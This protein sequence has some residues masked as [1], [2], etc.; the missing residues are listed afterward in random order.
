MYLKSV[1]EEVE[2]LNL[3]NAERDE[4]LGQLR[5]R[6]DEFSQR[7]RILQD[8]IVSAQRMSDEMQQKA[9]SEADLLLREARMNAERRL[10]ESQDQLSRIENEISRL[11]L[12][13]DSF[14]KRLRGL[15]EQHLELLDLRSSE[16][17]EQEGAN[18]MHVLPQASVYEAG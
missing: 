2:R 5:A 12:E 11:R 18:P 10:Q 3:E 16:R 9:R 7:E 8:A 4:E 1:G 14:E 6:I 13:R 15:V 17:R